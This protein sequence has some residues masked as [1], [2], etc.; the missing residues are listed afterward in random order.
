M[1]PVIA[2]QS[3]LQHHFSCWLA[4]RRT[5]ARIW[6]RQFAAAR[7]AIVLCR[8]HRGRSPRPCDPHLRV[9]R[10]HP[11]SPPDMIR[12]NRTSKSP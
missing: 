11:S 1:I 9:N 12:L 10:P 2:N 8:M 5:Q 3:P 4:A 7:I 6:Y